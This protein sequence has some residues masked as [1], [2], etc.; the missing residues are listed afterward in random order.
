MTIP[1]WNWG[2]WQFYCN[3]QAKVDGIGCTSYQHI[4]D[5]MKKDNPDAQSMLA[6]FGGEGERMPCMCMR[7]RAPLHMPQCVLMLWVPASRM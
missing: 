2:E 7:E 4:P 1:Y 5:N 6:A 3:E